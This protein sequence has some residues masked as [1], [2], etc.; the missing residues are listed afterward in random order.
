MEGNQVVDRAEAGRDREVHL[1]GIDVRQS[2]DSESGL[3]GYD[4]PPV[5][6]QRPTD[7]DVVS[8]GGPLGQPEERPVDPEPVA[9][10][11]VVLLGLVGV[12][13]LQ[14]L[15]RCEVAR[16]LERHGV[17]RP[18]KILAGGGHAESLADHKLNE[19]FSFILHDSGE[20]KMF[21]AA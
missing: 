7:V 16:L 11:G 19:I 8:I 10:V 15:C 4:A 17:K 9:G 6:P 3:V 12:A 1:D 14:R 2:V 18:A 21:Y 5:T 13:D 20:L